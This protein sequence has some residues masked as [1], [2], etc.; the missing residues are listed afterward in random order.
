MQIVST[1]IPI[2]S[3]VIIGWLIRLKGFVPPEFLG[4]ANRLVFYIAIPAMIFRS[5]AKSSFRAHFNP[6]VMIITLFSVVA[7][8]ILSWIAGKISIRERNNLG[9][10]IQSSIHGNLGYIGLAV[11]YYFMGQE[12]FV[13]AGIIGGF[14]MILQNL[15]AVTAL[16]LYGK[17]VPLRENRL[18]FVQK[19]FGNPVILSAMAGILFSVTETPV[20]E[21]IGRIL[22]ILGDLALPMALLVIGAS[23]SFEVMR[24]SVFSVISTNF[25]KLIA[26]PCTGFI[27]YSIYNI[28]PQEFL[29]GL[30]LLASPTATIAYIMAKEMD[31]D[32]DFAVAAISSSTLISAATFSFWL[33]VAG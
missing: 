30:I 25:F 12:G 7:V 27:L 14:I 16:V 23:L 6:T 26:L 18:F 2:F 3:I 22:D 5:V 28:A 31:G 20:P 9:T 29:P 1:I 33:N 32:A 15:L 10:Y 21:V 13:K 8:F 17:D 11:A 24:L 19:I 4:P